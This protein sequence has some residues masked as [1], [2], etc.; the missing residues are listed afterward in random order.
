[1]LLCALCKMVTFQ[2]LNS[3][4]VIKSQVEI[5]QFLQTTDI[6]YR[7]RQWHKLYNAATTPYQADCKMSNCGGS[8]RDLY[9]RG[10][11]CCN[12]KCSPILEMRLPCKYRIFRSRHHLSRC[13][14]LQT[15]AK[16]CGYLLQ[17]GAVHCNTL[18]QLYTILTAPLVRHL[19]GTPTVRLS[20]H[21][22]VFLCSY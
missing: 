13:S 16:G 1:M 12:L 17:C 19:C 2:L 22:P 4:D 5:L 14:I 20:A 9:Y 8:T 3:C 11:K 6:L 21:P 15:R 18:A 10:H 7:Q